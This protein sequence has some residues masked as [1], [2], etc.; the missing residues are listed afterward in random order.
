MQKGIEALI[1]NGAAGQHEL[2][3]RETFVRR[4]R[5]AN[6]TKVVKLHAQKGP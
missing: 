3:C 6:R 4:R 2:G 1:L 5:C